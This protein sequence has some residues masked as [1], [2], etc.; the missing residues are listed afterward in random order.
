MYID[1]TLEV[2]EKIP[3][4]PGDPKM[5]SRN[6][7]TIKKYAVN[8]KRVSFNSHF[9]THID[10]PFHML[11]DGKKLEEFEPDYFI[12]QT[13]VIDVRGQKLI[14]PNLLPKKITAPIIFFYTNHIANI[15]H[16]NYFKNN[17]VI[18]NET[19]QSIVQSKVKVV[20]IDSFTPDNFPYEVHKILFAK[21]ILIVENLTNL[22]LI[23]EKCRVIIAPLKLTCADGAP[24]RIFAQI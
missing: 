9:S 15:F 3:P 19:A 23:G 16:N 6:L 20:G 5:E 12:G 2:S 11:T 10:A 8:E 13:Q 7:F 18:T 21:N 14:T 17:P 22:G 4:F 24:A 1:L